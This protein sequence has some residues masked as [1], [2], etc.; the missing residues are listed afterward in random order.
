[1]ENIKEIIT[2]FGAFKNKAKG[3]EITF[4]IIQSSIS[5]WKDYLETMIEKNQWL[6]E[7]ESNPNTLLDCECF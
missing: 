6:C 1:M 2:D 3:I 4:N 7:I 5:L